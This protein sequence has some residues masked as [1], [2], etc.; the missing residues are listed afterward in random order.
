[1]LAYGAVEY[2]EAKRPD[3]PAGAEQAEPEEG[4][5]TELAM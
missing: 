4:K 2:L 3:R 1:M 5:E